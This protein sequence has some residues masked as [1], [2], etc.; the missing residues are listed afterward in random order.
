MPTAKIA[1]FNLESALWGVPGPIRRR[2]GAWHRRRALR[3]GLTEFAADPLAALS[4]Q[5][6]VLPKLIYGWGNESWSALDEYLRACIKDAY[7]LRGPILECGS[8]LSTLLLG[9]VAARCG[10][11]VLTLE[12]NAEWGAK[13]SAHLRNAGIR[14]VN[15][16]VHPLKDYGEYVW[17]D[18]IRPD[19]ATKFA[20]VVCDGP[21]GSGRGGRYGLVP[22]M[23]DYFGFGT[24]IL[25]DDAARDGEQEAAR[26]WASETGAVSSFI[27]GDKPYIRLTIP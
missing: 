26:K 7:E 6:P 5:S 2:L 1:P 18:P 19:L 12:N 15:V 20:L 21:P 25:L 23:R 13:V 9:I 10:T 8:G 14:T 4:L 22:V 27:P 24:V 11:W 16:D 3:Q 17:Y